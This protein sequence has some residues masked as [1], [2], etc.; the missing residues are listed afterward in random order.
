MKRV[1]RKADEL[2]PMPLPW[3]TRSSRIESVEGTGCVQRSRGLINHHG[4]RPDYDKG[5]GKSG[6]YRA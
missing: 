5:A 4:K 2:L 3:P 1:L 6:P